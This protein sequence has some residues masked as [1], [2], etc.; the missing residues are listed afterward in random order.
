MTDP[1]TKKTLTVNVI[2]D[3]MPTS[4]F[5]DGKYLSATAADQ[6]LVI[7][8]SKFTWDATKKVALDDQVRGMLAL[9]KKYDKPFVFLV[10]EG[11]D[12]APAVKRFADAIGVE[13]KVTPDVSGRI[14]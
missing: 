10:K 9:A 2:P 7:A 6:A 5:K 1:L 14:R 3:F 11:G 13:W 12:V 4:T 8:D